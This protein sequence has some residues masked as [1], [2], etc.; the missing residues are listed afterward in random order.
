MPVFS[1]TAIQISGVSTPS[2]S[3]VTIDCFTGGSFSVL[4]RKSQRKLQRANRIAYAP[5]EVVAV[6]QADR[7]NHRFPAQ[8]ATDRKQPGIEGIIRDS[9][10]HPQRIREKN[11]RPT[12]RQGLFKFYR[13]QRVGFGPNVLPLIVAR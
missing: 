10:R 13:A 3:S 2:M 5:V 11:Q 8:S 7:A 4:E 6:F 1:A 12:G 9:L